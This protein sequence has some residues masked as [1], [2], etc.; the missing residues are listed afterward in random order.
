MYNLKNGLLT[1]KRWPECQYKKSQRRQT[2]KYFISRI[3]SFRQNELQSKAN[4]KTS[5]IKFVWKRH[6]LC[7]SFAMLTQIVNGLNGQNDIFFH[8]FNV[9]SVSNRE[10]GIIIKRHQFPSTMKLKRSLFHGT[11]IY[12]FYKTNIQQ[13]SMYATKNIQPNNQINL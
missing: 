4:H 7:E 13:Q 12:I 8:I 1:K 5:K 2:G 11:S 6:V 9:Y 3:I 10:S